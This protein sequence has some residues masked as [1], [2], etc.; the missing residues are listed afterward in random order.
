MIL[1]RRNTALFVFFFSFWSPSKKIFNVQC[2]HSFKQTLTNYLTVSCSLIYHCFE[3]V[4]F[5]MLRSFTLLFFFLEFLFT[6]QHKLK[7]RL[8]KIIYFYLF[9]TDLIC[10]ENTTVFFICC[11]IFFP[12]WLFNT[13]YPTKCAGT[14]LL[15]TFKLL[16]TFKLRIY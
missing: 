14:T 10:S 15:Q 5:N 7:Q 4:N 6:H 9:L 8:M 11:F 13:P 16:T 3:F 1:A 12:G 2:C